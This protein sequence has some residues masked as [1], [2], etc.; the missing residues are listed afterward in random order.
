M[1]AAVII[2]CIILFFSF[3]I[4]RFLLKELKREE[5]R[6]AVEILNTEAVKV[7]LYLESIDNVSKKIATS[8]NLQKTLSD[9]VQRLGIQQFRKIEEVVQ[10]SVIFTNADK[11]KI[12]IWDDQKRMRYYSHASVGEDSLFLEKIDKIMQD[13]AY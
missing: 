4:F 10:N 13:D 9:S 12:F 11:M 1:G 2:A 3:F 5:Y 6:N 8:Q 7:E